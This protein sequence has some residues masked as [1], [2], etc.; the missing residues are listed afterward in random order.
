[1]LNVKLRTDEQIVELCP[2]IM[3]FVLRV[4]LSFH[5]CHTLCCKCFG[6]YCIN[7]ICNCICHTRVPREG[8]GPWLWADLYIILH[9]LWVKH[10]Q[11]HF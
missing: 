2:S 8:S 9:P 4:D 10:G 3:K 7:V 1:M 5:P 6:I 11:V